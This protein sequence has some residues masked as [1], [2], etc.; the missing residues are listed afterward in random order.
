[1]DSLAGKKLAQG[2]PLPNFVNFFIQT[3]Y[4]AQE[5]PQPNFVNLFIQ[6]SYLAQGIP[7]TNLKTFYT[8]LG[9]PLGIVEKMETFLSLE[10]ELMQG[11]L[12]SLQKNQTRKSH[13]TISL[14]R[15]WW[16]QILHLICTE[17]RE[18]NS[19][20]GSRLHKPVCGFVPQLIVCLRRIHK[21]TNTIPVSFSFPNKSIPTYL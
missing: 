7:Q 13:A 9:I 20:S 3:L 4:L 8:N 19:L 21:R 15:V 12:Y 1:M 5:I 16:L 11:G 10:F 18:I 2:I 14:K 17:I 6:P